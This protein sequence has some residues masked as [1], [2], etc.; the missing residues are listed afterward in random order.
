MIRRHYTGLTPF[1]LV[2]I[3]MISAAL[4]LIF[5]PFFRDIQS[6]W[7]LLGLAVSWFIFIHMCILASRCLIMPEFICFIACINW[8][9]APALSYIYPPRFS[10]YRMII[11][12]DEYF[13]YIV[14]ATLCL[15]L[16]IHTPLKLKT[17]GFDTPDQDI[18]LNKHDRRI[19]DYFIITG[20]LFS[21]Y[22]GHMPGG[23]GGLKF[24]YIIL[25]QLRFVGA[26]A[27]LFTETKGWRWRVALVYGTFFIQIA[28]GGIFYEF[29]LWSG[30]LFISLAYLRRWRWRLPFLLAALVVL[31]TVFNTVKVEYRRQTSNVEMSAFRRIELLRTLYLHSIA[32]KKPDAYIGDD[33][34]RWNQGWIIARVMTIVPRDEPYARGQTVKDA[35]TAALM[36]RVFMKNKEV[37][38]SQ[39]LFLKYAKLSL[40][41]GTAMALSVAGEFYANFGRLGGI[42]AMYVYGF[43]VG[44][45]FSRF[46]RLAKKNVLW[47]AWAPFVMLTTLE[48]EWNLVDVVNQVTKSLVVMMALLCLFPQFRAVFF[49]RRSSAGAGNSNKS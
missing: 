6:F 5:A 47:W 38:G 10:L 34:V 24:F 26:L 11:P 13:S 31:I 17:R 48:A 45:L 33:L 20:L 36:P 29:V 49:K 16:S 35:L 40:S 14:P 7:M 23:T 44:F 4:A 28:V 21:V 19:M 42:V 32:E 30:Y 12:S 37:G 41:K 18:S 25:T 15:W 2:I 46:A 3:G 43:L 1:E 9:L 39:A 8:I 27:Y 22:G